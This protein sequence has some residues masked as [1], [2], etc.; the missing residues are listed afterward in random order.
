MATVAALFP[1][2]HPYHWLTIGSPDDL[3]ASTLDEARAFFE[4]YYHPRNASLAIAGDVTAEAALDLANAYFG[5]RAREGRW[6][7]PCGGR[8]SS[9]DRSR[10][11]HEDR[12][13]LPRLYLAWHSPAMFAPGDAELDLIA[14]V[15]SN[16]KNSRL[17]HSLV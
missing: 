15:L 10:L 5:E 9:Q 12:I 6:S 1:P 14:D 7:T 2:D 3:R 4:R 17:Y 13:E 11:L 8:R 16:G